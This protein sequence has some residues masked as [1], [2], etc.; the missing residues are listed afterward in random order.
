MNPHRQQR[1]VQP[2]RLPS[3][4]DT[5]FRRLQSRPAGQ[6]DGFFQLSFFL[7]KATAYGSIERLDPRR[8]RESIGRW[9]RRYLCIGSPEQTIHTEN[10]FNFTDQGIR[11]LL[12]EVGFNIRE[13]WKDTRGW[14]TLTL[15]CLPVGLRRCC[16]AIAPH[17]ACSCPDSNNQQ[18]AELS[19]WA[20]CRINGYKQ[21]LVAEWLE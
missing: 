3:A 7:A 18:S 14:Y 21:S 10:S 4:S 17:L 2:T 12:E 9:Y 19:L 6:S 8:S 5:V 15:A 1:S 20:K 13:T 16:I 11:S